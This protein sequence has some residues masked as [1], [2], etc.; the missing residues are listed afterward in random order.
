MSSQLE[1]LISQLSKKGLSEEQIYE[2]LLK[3]K[4][5]KESYT[6]SDIYAYLAKERMASNILGRS[7]PSKAIGRRIFGAL[8][9]AGSIYILTNVCQPHSGRLGSKVAGYAIALA[10]LGLILIFKPRAEIDI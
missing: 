1:N 10:I 2:N 4:K 7:N 3:S 9:L 6:L 5:I 8:C